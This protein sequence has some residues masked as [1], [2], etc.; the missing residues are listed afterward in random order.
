MSKLRLLGVEETI[1]TWYDETA[2]HW[3]PIMLFP[4]NELTPEL[5]KKYSNARPAS[6]HLNTW[7][8][9][10]SV[11]WLQEQNSWEEGK[12]Q[13][14]FNQLNS[15]YRF[16]GERGVF[17]LYLLNE[18]LEEGFEK[19]LY[20]DFVARKQDE[21]Y[22]RMKASVIIEGKHTQRVFRGRPDEM[23]IYWRPNT[24]IVVREAIGSLTHEEVTS[25]ISRSDA[26]VSLKS[27][28]SSIPARIESLRKE[29]AGDVVKF[30]TTAEVHHAFNSVF[31]QLI[32]RDQARTSKRLEKISE[33]YFNEIRLLLNKIYD[34]PLLVSKNLISSN[35]ALVIANFLKDYSSEFEFEEFLSIIHSLHNP[36]VLI[37]GALPDASKIYCE[38]I[39]LENAKAVESIQMISRIILEGKGDIPVQ[40]DWIKAVKDE[41]LIDALV[42]SIALELVNERSL[43]RVWSET[44]RRF[45]RDVPYLF[46]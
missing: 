3:G 38:A 11:A 26:Y 46:K 14:Y 35:D 13:A 1:E 30:V 40:E 12:A 15:A 34:D 10:K 19:E 2:K 28:V 20:R 27:T 24:R 33:F 32:E 7:I 8:K 29:L 45:L 42:P 39:K 16:Y 18:F 43:K 31:I 36:A 41:I 22:A 23:L 9:D 17:A 37:A 25:F 4:K 44:S 21:V 5:R 6:T